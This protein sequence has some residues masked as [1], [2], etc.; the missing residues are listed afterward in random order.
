MEFLYF[1]CFFRVVIFNILLVSKFIPGSVSY[2]SKTLNKLRIIVEIIVELGKF[3][4]IQAKLW[5]T[6]MKNL[7]E[8]YLNLTSIMS[9]AK[10]AK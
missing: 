10:S 3:W 8:L 7:T 1:L 9:I 4:P 6:Y 5:L 2:L